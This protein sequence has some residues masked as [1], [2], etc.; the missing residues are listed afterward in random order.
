MSHAFILKLIE[1]PIYGE[2]QHSA[3]AEK[4]HTISQQH[5]SEYCTNSPYINCNLFC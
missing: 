1:L 5:F 2:F 3:A 4:L